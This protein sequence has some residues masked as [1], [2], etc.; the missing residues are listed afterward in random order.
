MLRL[1]QLLPFV[2]LILFNSCDKNSTKEEPIPEV[3]PMIGECL[4]TSLTFNNKPFYTFEY[5][6][7][8]L[9]ESMTY[10]I[11]E[12]SG[13]VT[14]EYNDNDQLVA[15]HAEDHSVEDII[16]TQDTIFYTFKE[17]NGEYPGKFV[18][19]DKGRPYGKL[20]RT[21]D[22]KITIRV[23]YNE[24]DQLIAEYQSDSQ[25]E[26]LWYENITFD[27]NPYVLGYF[28]LMYFYN[29]QTTKITWQFY[30]WSRPNNVTQSVRRFDN[31]NYVSEYEY[32]YNEFGYPIER[33]IKGSTAA[34]PSKYEYYCY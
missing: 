32:V 14:F 21:D 19:D 1:K 27:N 30:P 26:R 3:E 25:E 8:N 10:N 20:D 17:N 16:Y 34:T 22:T 23:E 29:T 12:A 5:N 28:P 2:F 4:L 11:F 9:R 18:V 13:T 6:E 33:T 7:R 24:K 15:L 31:S